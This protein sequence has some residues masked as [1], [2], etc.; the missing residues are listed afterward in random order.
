MNS[1]VEQP[2]NLSK[3]DDF[4]DRLD[5]QIFSHSEY[6]LC[7]MNE[8]THEKL[9][10]LS[11]FSKTI[12]SPHILG[13][14]NNEQHYLQT[15]RLVLSS[16]HE[17]YNRI[18]FFLNKILP[19]LPADG[20]LLDI[21]P[22]DGSLTKSLIH[23]FKDITLVDINHHALHNLQKTLPPLIN[24]LQISESIL[25]VNLKPNCYNLAVLS[26]MLYYIKPKLWLKIIK[27]VYNSLKDNG[28]LVIILGGD[29]LDKAELIQHFGE[30]TL[31]IDKL[32]I[33]CRNTFGATNVSFYAS[34]ES[35]VACS[36][37]AMLHIS[38][39]MLADANILAPKE[40]LTNYIHK[41]FKKSDNHFEM[42][43]IQKYIIITK[44]G[45]LKDAADDSEIVVTNYQPKN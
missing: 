44:N 25:N 6:E 4:F 3:M 29:E 13:K 19:K 12:E 27:S 30:Q 39:F 23:N 45:H 8:L 38:A 26:H 22:G 7:A 9:K 17:T 2:H 40:A 14:F 35:F 36:E 41:E 33:K 31:E 18:T 10:T 20:S 24:L 5:Y 32:A 1:I 43:T 11:D 28:I 34:N 21:G 16:T 42:T 15:L 37:E